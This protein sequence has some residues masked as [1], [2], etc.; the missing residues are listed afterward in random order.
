VHLGEDDAWDAARQTALADDIK[1]MPMGLH[2]MVTDGGSAFS[3]G[4]VQRI[5]L[6]RALAGKPRIL[7]LD[8]ATSAL[9]NETQA[10]VTASLNRIAATRLVIAHRLSTV[11]QADRIIVLNNGAVEEVGSYDELMLRNGF[12]AAF[13]QRQLTA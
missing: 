3:G 1:A 9:D 5:L 12:F 10:I 8:E 7:L 11:Q 6:A 4:Q 13:A 2:T